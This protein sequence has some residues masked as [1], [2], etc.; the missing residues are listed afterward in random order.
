MPAHEIRWSEDAKADLKKLRVSVARAV[1]QAVSEQLT[2]EPLV[3]TRHRKPLKDLSGPWSASDGLW[4]LSVGHYRA[5]YAVV[6][7]CVVVYGIR[8]K[9]TRMTKEIL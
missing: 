5:F 3:Q 1:S 9:G 8:H 2:W 4:Q 6:G 7:G